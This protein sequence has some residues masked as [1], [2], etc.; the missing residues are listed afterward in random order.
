MTIKE[1]LNNRNIL[2]EENNSI[3][4]NPPD[5][6][7]K[8]SILI[9]EN[10]SICQS[11]IKYMRN[12]Y[13]NKISKCSFCLS[14]LSQ[15]ETNATLVLVQELCKT[16][17]IS[18][19]YIQDKTRIHGNF[20]MIPRIT[21]FLNG[22]FLELYARYIAETVISNA[23]SENNED[24]ELLHNIIV[25]KN[26]QL[27][28][29]DLLMRISDKL[30]WCEVKSGSYSSFEKYYNLGKWLNVNPEMHIL[31]SAEADSKVCESASFF[32]SFYISNISDFKDKLSLM[33]NNILYI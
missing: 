4:L 25:R 12:C 22:D 24:Y 32:Y 2:I 6:I 7:I 15:A 20:S 3:I 19:L 5:S 18:D 30:F 33:I 17:I 27:H 29:L 26:D 14:P 8:L 1:I 21:N 16:G 10:Y 13:S 11:F 23:A 28:E 31:L 9:A